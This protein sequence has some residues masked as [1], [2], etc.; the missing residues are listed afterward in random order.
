MSTRRITL[1]RNCFLQEERRGVMPKVYA[2]ITYQS[3]S[4]SEKQTV[5]SKLAVPAVTPFGAR[6]LAFDNAVVALEYG[7]KERTVV[8]EYPSVE[9]DVAAYGRRD[10]YYRQTAGLISER[11]TIPPSGTRSIELFKKL[12]F[13]KL[14][15]R[16][17]PPLRPERHVPNSIATI[18]RRLSAALVAML[19][20]CPC[21]VATIS[22]QSRRQN[23]L[24]Q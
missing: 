21:C 13:P 11:E 16:G 19:S 4:N 2:V 10:N 1:T 23:F 17:G 12:Q 9:E 7:L 6:I 15:A 24:T 20:R 18:R 22:A 5:Y 3:I 14:T 8:V